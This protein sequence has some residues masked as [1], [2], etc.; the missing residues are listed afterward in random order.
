MTSINHSINQPMSH[1][2]NQ[3]VKVDLPN[4][5]SVNQSTNQPKLSVNQPIFKTFIQSI[6]EPIHLSVRS[7][8][9]SVGHYYFGQLMSQFSQ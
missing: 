8:Q 3:S 1:L 6:K 4:S 7:C 5:Q 2:I 9:W